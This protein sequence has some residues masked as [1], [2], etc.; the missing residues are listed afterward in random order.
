MRTY[1]YATLTWCWERYSE[2]EFTNDHVTLSAAAAPA[3]NTITTHRSHKQ[4]HSQNTHGND[5]YK[6]SP[7]SCQLPAGNN[8]LCSSQYGTAQ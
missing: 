1:R 7:F 6:L 4:F 5:N 8:H 3:V 2:D